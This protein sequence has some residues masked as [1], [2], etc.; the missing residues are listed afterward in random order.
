MALSDKDIALLRE[1]YPL[2]AGTIKLN[3]CAG[4]KQTPMADPVRGEMEGAVANPSSIPL[5][6]G[7]NKS[8]CD[9]PGTQSKRLKQSG[10]PRLN[11]LETQWLAQLRLRYGTGLLIHEQAWRVEIANG[12]WYK[13]D[14]CAFIEGKWTCWECKGPSAVKGCGKGI[15]AFKCAASKFP[16]CRWILVWKVKGQ[17]HEQ[18]AIP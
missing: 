15:L 9:Y 1:K 6:N 16:E 10:K 8:C 2:S 5:G 14:L 17:W 12:A 7:L 18:L 3:L 11:K 4:G 13:V